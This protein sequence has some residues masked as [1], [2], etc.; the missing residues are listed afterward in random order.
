MSNASAT[1]AGPGTDTVA[2]SATSYACLKVTHTPAREYV[3]SGAAPVLDH[4]FMRS[5]DGSL[6][7][8]RMSDSGVFSVSG[9]GP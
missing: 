9:A 2:N 8:V 7:V 4:F 5:P 6:H 1:A 3:A